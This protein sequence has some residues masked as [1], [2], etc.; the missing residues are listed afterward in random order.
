MACRGFVTGD[1]GMPEGFDPSNL[2]PE[3]ML[4]PVEKMPSISKL[5]DKP[6]NT[7]HLWS[8]M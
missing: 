3:E 7:S 5:Q 6:V 4:P 2:K 1:W 8:G